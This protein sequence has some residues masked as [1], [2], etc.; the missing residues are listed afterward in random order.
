MSLPTNLS[1]KARKEAC[2][3]YYHKRKSTGGFEKDKDGNLIPAS[4]AHRSLTKQA[5]AHASNINN[6]VKTYKQTG[7]LGNPNYASQIQPMYVDMSTLPN[8]HEAQNAIANAK[9]SFEGLP[10]HIR[11]KFENDPQ[12]LLDFMDDPNTLE[13]QYKLG[14]KI[15]PKD[16]IGN[17]ESEAHK[18]AIASTDD[19]E[20]TAPTGEN[21]G[22]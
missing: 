12:K 15:K 9:S 22:A 14:L 1:R 18:N 3:K 6:I 17:T 8:L 16:L 4:P 10:S 21:S 5:F 2:I 20:T 7:V 11:N 13:E 19:S